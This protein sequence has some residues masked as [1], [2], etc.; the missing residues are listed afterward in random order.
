[1]SN[2]TQYVQACCPV[3]SLFSSLIYCPRIQD[4]ISFSRLGFITDQC[5][6]VKQ[7]AFITSMNLNL[8]RKLY[9]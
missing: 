3:I 8:Q 5:I 6:A 2:N 4:L 1:M 9:I 7:H